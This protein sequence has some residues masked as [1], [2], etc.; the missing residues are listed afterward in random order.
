[1]VIK[2]K[3]ID[4]LAVGDPAVEVYNDSKYGFLEEFKKTKDIDVNFEIVSFNKYYEELMES[5]QKYKY[6]VVMVAGHLWLKEFVEK[7]YLAELKLAAAQNYNYL[8][9]VAEIR[10]ELELDGRRYLLPSFSDGHILIYRKSDKTKN[11]AEKITIKELIAVV[12]SFEKQSAPL[13]LKADASEIFLDL[14]PYFRARSLEPFSE[15]GQFLLNNQ[16][17]RAALND[18]LDLKKYCQKNVINFGNQEVKE[19]I[20]K[21]EVELAVTWSGQLG[22]VMDEHCLEKESLDFAYFEQPWKTTWSFALNNLSQKKEAAAEFMYYITS[23]KVDKV[24]G[25]HCGNPTR[26]SNFEADRDK[27]RWYKVVLKMLTN[28]KSLPDLKNT[29]SLIGSCSCEFHQA[30]MGKISAEEALN[31]IEKL[32]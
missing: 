14:L 27:F 28:S 9:I 6:D 24:V 3:S 4:V 10:E 17:G 13:V 7:G 15:T 25:A 11:I 19:A 1:M 18:Y 5:F 8:D 16:S 29:G 32:I 31:N 22:T 21:K 2:I 20:Q 23:Q 30:L 12:K 26:F